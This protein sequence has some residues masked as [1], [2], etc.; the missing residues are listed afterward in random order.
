MA[1]M[2]VEKLWTA[3]NGYVGCGFCKYNFYFPINIVGMFVGRLWTKNLIVIFICSSA[4]RGCCVVVV[5]KKLD[6]Y[7]GGVVCQIYFVFH[8]KTMRGRL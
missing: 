6:G 3:I 2:V 5:V 4:L 7:F 8:Y 1:T